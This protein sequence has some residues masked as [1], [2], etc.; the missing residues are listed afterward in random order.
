M[1]PIYGCCGWDWVR[2]VQRSFPKAELTVAQGSILFHAFFHRLQKSPRLGKS[3]LYLPIPSGD[4]S[5]IKHQ[6]KKV[7]EG[8]DPS[9]DFQ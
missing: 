5:I 9:R 6:N 3:W 2:A 1:P 7:A 4:Q 8:E